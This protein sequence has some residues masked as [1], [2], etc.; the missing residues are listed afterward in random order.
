MI[1]DLVD[2]DLDFSHPDNIQRLVGHY[3]DVESFV[4]QAFKLSLVPLHVLS[5][6]L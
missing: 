1:D 4:M 5:I 6:V 2:F 3:R